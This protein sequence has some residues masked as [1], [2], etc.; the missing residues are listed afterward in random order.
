MM[1]ATYD[2]ELSFTGA[3]ASA[4]TAPLRPQLN[5]VLADCQRFMFDS[6]PDPLGSLLVP[7]MSASYHSESPVH[8][9]SLNASVLSVHDGVPVGACVDQCMSEGPAHMD[10]EERCL[11]HQKS[12][13]RLVLHSA[14]IEHIHSFVENCK[15]IF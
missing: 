15:S 10:D 3:S 7:P 14:I 4:G 2:I 6:L 1:T 11:Q 5:A 9:R 13:Q 8:I 12:H